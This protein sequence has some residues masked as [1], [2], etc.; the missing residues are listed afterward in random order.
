MKSA[1]H[2]FIKKVVCTKE[3]YLK[4]IKLFTF[5]YNLIWDVRL[6]LIGL[7][8]FVYKLIDIILSF[9]HDDINVIFNDIL[10]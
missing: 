1:H 6:L 2:L 8:L 9:D 7:E 3:R 4:E 10:F 5:R